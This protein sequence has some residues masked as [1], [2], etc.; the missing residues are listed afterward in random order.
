MPRKSDLQTQ[1]RPRRKRLA[2]GQRRYRVEVTGKGRRPETVYTYAY[3]PD[4][5]R[6]FAHFQKPGHQVGKAAPD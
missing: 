3:S 1:H 6:R 5:A 4:Q 2:N